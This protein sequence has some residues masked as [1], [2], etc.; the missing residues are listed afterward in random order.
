MKFS[1]LCAGL[2]VAAVAPAQITIYSNDFEAGNHLGF[3]MGGIET[4][5]NQSTKFLGR[6]ANEPNN[7]STA[8]TL[9]GLAS[10]TSVTLSL[11]LYIIHSW[12]G[13][14][15]PGPDQL[16]FQQDGSDLLNAT[17]ANQTSW[18]QTYSDATP[19]GG[20]PFAGRTDHDAYATLGYGDYYGSDMTYNLTFT[21]AHSASTLNLSFAGF[22]LQAVG[23]E[24]WG[25]DNV[26]VKTDAVPE[27]ASM[28]A[29]GLG[30]LALRR[31][32]R[33]R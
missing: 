10:H 27:P 15:G 14:T 31:R 3:T 24:S 23:D 4:A 6:F 18:Q 19:L 29:L 21:F 8:L 30:I 28:A 16:V 9:T 32:I 12:D 11:D 1:L 26:L 13:V 17:F 5:P 33:A 2:F 20:G 7:T 22:N 25:I